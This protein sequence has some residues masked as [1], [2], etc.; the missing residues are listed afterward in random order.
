MFL[1]LQMQPNLCQIGARVGCGSRHHL[2]SPKMAEARQEAAALLEGK[3]MLVEVEK[4]GEGALEL[5][6]TSHLGTMAKK[7]KWLGGI[8]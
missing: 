3:S 6:D 7:V 4:K 1:M 2:G 5:S 8:E